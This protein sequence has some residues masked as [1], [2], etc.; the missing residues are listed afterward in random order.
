[1]IKFLKE[2]FR[3]FLNK[4]T[5]QSYAQEGEDILLLR[6]LNP[7]K[8]GFYIDIGAHHPVRFSNTY[9]LYQKGWSG[10][11]VD[12]NPFN[13]E[14]F[15]KIR[16]RDICLSVGVSDQ[17]GNLEYFVFNDGALN[18]FSNERALE[19]ENSTSYRVIKKQKVPV[20]TL[21]NI[22]SKHLPKHQK[23]DVLSIDIEGFDLAVLKSNNWN[24]YSPQTIILE[25]HLI[26]LENLE[27]S[28]THKFMKSVG[29]TL[30]SKL[31]VSC[32]YTKL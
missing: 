22:L 23:I 14:L 31:H 30:T 1:M 6:T 9:Q 13:M 8:N 3:I 2:F 4:Y 18:T 7:E 10:I 20:E 26:D 27:N 12:A 11:C 21:S 16:S 19:L 17:P 15:K 25:D 24:L 32:F 28:E 29:Y 5:F